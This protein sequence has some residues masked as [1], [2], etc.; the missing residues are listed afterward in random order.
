MMHHFEEE[1]HQARADFAMTLSSDISAGRVKQHYY[2]KRKFLQW[3]PVS[4]NFSASFPQHHKGCIFFTKVSGPGHSKL[5]SATQRSVVAPQCNAPVQK[6]EPKRV[7]LINFWAKFRLVSC[8]AGTG[9]QPC[10]PPSTPI[11]CVNQHVPPGLR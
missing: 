2:P 7:R 4:V 8:F 9:G 5:V 10:P 3:F 6:K 1:H 11:Q